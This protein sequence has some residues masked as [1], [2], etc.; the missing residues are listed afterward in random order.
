MVRNQNGNA[1]LALINWK[2]DIVQIKENR[3][4]DHKNNVK[5]CI[6]IRNK[7]LQFMY[8]DAKCVVDKKFNYSPSSIDLQNSTVPIKSALKFTC[9]DSFYFIENDLTGLKKNYFL[10]D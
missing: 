2:L 3:N 6:C 1:D 5:V 10:A 9:D 4:F 8:L 7:R